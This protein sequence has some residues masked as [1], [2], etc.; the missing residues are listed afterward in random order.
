MVAGQWEEGWKAL[1]HISEE[2]TK[3]I[4]L[5]TITSPSVPTSALVTD[6]DTIASSTAG[7][8][9]TM[10]AAPGTG[11]LERLLAVQSQYVR[12]LCL[13]MQGG[14]YAAL[15][16]YVVITAGYREA[17][18]DRLWRAP[19]FEPFMALAMYRYGVLCVQLAGPRSAEL[20]PGSP[21]RGAQLLHDA[22]VA[23]RMFLVFS[24]AGG[25]RVGPVRRLVAMR[26]YAQ[27]LEARF[28]RQAFRTAFAPDQW[29][30]T[31]ADGNTV[32][33]PESVQEDLL[34]TTL[35]L[36]AGH[37]AM[38]AENPPERRQVQAGA[39]SH[40]QRTF[41]RRLARYRCTQLLVEQVEGLFERYAANSGLYGNLIL[42][43]AAAGEHER[44]LL[45]GEAYCQLGGKEPSVLLAYGKAALRFGRA[46]CIVALLQGRLK[47]VSSL[48]MEDMRSPL[49][50][51][52]ATAL[53]LVAR[54]CLPERPAEALQYREEAIQVL[55]SAIAQDSDAPALH[56]ALGMAHM[57][58]GRPAEAERHVK[59]SLALDASQARA[60][61]LLALLRTAAQD[62]TGALAICDMQIELA[63]HPHLDTCLLK[64]ALH[65]A[66][67][68][69][70]DALELMKA[71]FSHWVSPSS[72]TDG[73]DGIAAWLAPLTVSGSEEDSGSV[74]T[75]R[76]FRQR[77]LHTHAHQDIE[78]PTTILR[79]QEIAKHFPLTPE[80]TK[81]TLLGLPAGPARH[82]NPHDR[83]A[84]FEAQ[85]HSLV[86]EGGKQY[87]AAKRLWLF[88]SKLYLAERKNS[89]ATL[90]AEAA[91]AIDELDAAVYYRLGRIQEAQGLAAEAMS[92]YSRGL[93]IDPSHAG[94]HLGLARRL[95]ALGRAGEPERL[96]AAFGHARAAL[97]TRPAE[98][99]AMGLLAE[100]NR[101]QG[102]EEQAMHWYR[103]ALETEQTAPL[104]YTH[105]AQILL[106]PQ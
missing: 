73:P 68:A 86:Q 56:L 92:H 57:E 65:Q 8:E 76:R 94:C 99:R 38:E 58:A 33:V 21:C 67:G 59:A 53:L 45:A 3:A 55:H 95:T 7:T 85:Q 80:Q 26:R 82:L 34:L 51:L 69:G 28:P 36:E 27:A 71:V 10:T 83:L 97:R 37:A 42:A 88:L 78:P 79:F 30:V 61:Y 81:C 98:H 18:F 13:E 35:L 2:D 101:L 104:L 39:M 49:S 74:A 1:G 4:L 93:Q 100:I 77:F 105:P 19:A 24:A 75:I 54:Q 41:T 22:G 23:L 48:E 9:G 15:S 43:L 29:Q 25:A 106:P 5:T 64:A 72:S 44:T 87:G 102:H 20:P 17:P 60:W 50:T 89:D 47:D 11:I 12:G 70:E 90:A 14:A 96:G 31:S 63:A 66:M 40:R 46:Q 16:A 84:A 52:L 32:F 103:Q 91:F 6:T 62:H